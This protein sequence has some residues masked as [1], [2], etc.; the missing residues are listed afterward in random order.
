MPVICTFFGIVIR[1]F[2]ADH[3]PPHFHA[4][5]Q[6]QKA[7]FDFNGELL[8]GSISSRRAKR[9]IREW[10]LLHQ[11]ELM[12]NWRN[13]EQGQPLSQIEPLD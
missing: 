4:E 9:L 3:P 12:L 5:H 1:M 6:G 8:A 2:F 11:F 10:A 7:S 13:I